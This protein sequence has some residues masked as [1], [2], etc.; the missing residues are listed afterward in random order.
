LEV[1]LVPKD[2]ASVNI[3]FSLR[4]CLRQHQKHTCC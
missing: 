1:L 3:V 2:L 4:W